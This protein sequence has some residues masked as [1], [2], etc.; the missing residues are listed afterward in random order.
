MWAAR[1]I[2]LL[3]LQPSR[4]AHGAVTKCCDQGQRLSLAGEPSCEHSPS[5]TPLE[6]ANG[7]QHPL[8]EGAYEERIAG[9]PL[10]GGEQYQ[11]IENV[12][13]VAMDGFGF[14]PGLPPLPAYCVDF[15]K[16]ITSAGLVALFCP[17][18]EPWRF[19]PEGSTCVEKCCREGELLFEDT[20][21]G[22][23]KCIKSNHTQDDWIYKK[24][25]TKITS[26]LLVQT[27]IFYLKPH[28]LFE[29]SDLD[30]SKLHIDN[31]GNLNSKVDNST[32]K[33]YCIDYMN[34]SSGQL[35]EIV[36][37]LN[38]LNSG[39][40]AV[41]EDFFPKLMNFTHNACLVLSLFCSLVT[42]MAYW[43]IKCRNKTT[44]NKI[45]LVNIFITFLTFLFL[46][47]SSF[48][49]LSSVQFQSFCPMFG[50]LFYLILMAT[51]TWVTIL[52][53]DLFWMTHTMRGPEEG[54]GNQLGFIVQKSLGP[55]FL[56]STVALLLLQDILQ[57][58]S[59]SQSW[60]TSHPAALAILGSCLLGILLLLFDLLRS[61]LHDSKD[62]FDYNSSTIR[63]SCAVGFGIPLLLT[64]ILAAF[65]LFL[66]P[67]SILNPLMGEGA[68][69]LLSS[70]IQHESPSRA[71][72]LFHL[73]LFCIMII[74][75]SLLIVIWCN[76][77][78]TRR[79]STRDP[80]KRENNDLAVYVKLFTLFGLTWSF[81][82]LDPLARLL[83]N[84]MAHSTVQYILSVTSTI[85][86]LRGV[87]LLFVFVSPK[88]VVE[89][90]RTKG[91]P[92]FKP[93]SPNINTASTNVSYST[94][95]QSNISREDT[96]LNKDGGIELK[97]CQ[98]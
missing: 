51:F 34:D 75:A 88:D 5:K 30:N 12:E 53:F 85:S 74:N 33:D 43:F 56:L 71:L 19:C 4:L 58:P 18:A 1:A 41:K 84:G 27:S 70:P 40:K 45:V 63:L 97:P 82:V 93:P 67:F 65:H 78:K 95:L 68:S 48:I 91:F 44:K 81:E 38:I 25:T 20:K 98:A 16:D 21:D 39:R 50:Y 47:L 36:L 13:S 54:S 83:G 72:L 3:T 29:V 59:L 62:C 55:S 22:V 66:E 86:L 69:C 76:I 96:A 90:L 79:N 11:V 57:W 26:S 37:K 80:G 60:H 87:F 8:P 17:E 24:Y 6:V 35:R 9:W 64:S 94:T 10:C 42:F 15:N 46:S 92:F 7:T 89:Y 2:L 14:K 73:P 77:R 52:G 28:N 31:K 32:T 23:I 49:K 61:Y